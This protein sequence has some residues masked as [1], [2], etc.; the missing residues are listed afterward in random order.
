VP[1]VHPTRLHAGGGRFHRAFNLAT[2]AFQGVLPSG[3][4]V[5]LAVRGDHFRGSRGFDPTLKFDDIELIRRLSRHGGF[6][7]VEEEVFVSDRRYRERGVARAILEYA[8]IVRTHGPHLRP[9]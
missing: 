5:C 1:P 2:R 8:L 6:G 9:R 7:I 3:A 4:G